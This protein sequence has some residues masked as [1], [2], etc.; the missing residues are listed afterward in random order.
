[1]CLKSEKSLSYRGLSIK[2]A[3]IFLQYK[4]DTV[5]LLEKLLLTRGF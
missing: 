4:Q 3:A 1:M 2:K 5:Y